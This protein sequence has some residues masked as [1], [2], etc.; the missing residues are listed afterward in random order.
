MS[1]ANYAH[2]PA[3]DGKT[4][5]IGEDDLRE[6]VSVWHDKCLADREASVVAPLAESREAERRLAGSIRVL[7]DEVIA[8]L[9]CEAHRITLPTGL[10]ACKCGERLSGSRASESFVTHLLAVVRAEREG[11]TP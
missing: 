1:Y 5:Y 8:A 7:R 9:A 2:C 3:C 10:P 4:H 11:A 6:G